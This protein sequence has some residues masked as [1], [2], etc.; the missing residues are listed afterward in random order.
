M[1]RAPTRA[2][3]PVK[4]I[5]L[6]VLDRKALGLG[7][8]PAGG[9]TP[10]GGKGSGVEQA[11]DEALAVAHDGGR[12]AGALVGDPVVLLG[13]RPDLVGAHSRPIIPVPPLRQPPQTAGVPKRW[14]RLVTV[15]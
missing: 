3:S 12:L 7:R 1:N 11:L 2:G 15:P 14:T 6:P 4:E 8:S 10:L 9:G 5:Q 13:D